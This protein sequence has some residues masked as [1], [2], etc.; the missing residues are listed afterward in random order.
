MLKIAR[1]MSDEGMMEKRL[2][3]NPEDVTVFSGHGFEKRSNIQGDV[4]ANEINVASLPEDM[5]AFIRKD[6]KPDINNFCYL[7]INALSDEETFGD[8]VNGDGMP[9]ETKHGDPCL[10]NE[11]STHGYKTYELFGHWY[12][13]HKNKHP[14]HAQGFVLYSSYDLDK[15]I[16]IILA[17][18]D[19]SKRP[20][21]CARVDKGI[22]P[23]TSMGIKVPFDLCSVCCEKH[24]T[25]DFVEDAIHEWYTDKSLQS[26]FADPGKFIVWHN[27]MH[28]KKHGTNIPGLARNTKE[29]CDHLKF[30]MGKMLPDGTK[31]YAI[32]HLPKCFDI[33]D[34]FSNADKVSQGL[35]KVAGR[36]GDSKLGG[37]FDFE[38]MH[39]P[40]ACT[41]MDDYGYDPQRRLFLLEGHSFING[42]A[43]AELAK[44]AEIEKE[45]ETKDRPKKLS[46]KDIQQLAKR[47][48]SDVIQAT[49]GLMNKMDEEHK[50]HPLPRDFMQKSTGRDI[51]E[52]VGAL[53]EA[54]II[55]TPEEF[56]ELVFRSVGNV[57]GAEEAKAK[58]H[59]FE[60]MDFGQT[61]LEMEKKVT[62]KIKD[63]FTK[64]ASSDE[65]IDSLAPV[66]AERT[67]FAPF[68]QKR[69]ERE[70]AK[71]GREGA[72]MMLDGQGGYKASG[73]MPIHKE[74]LQGYESL[75]HKQ[76]A[77]EFIKDYNE[78]DR[79][80]MLKTFALTS[81]LYPAVRNQIASSIGGTKIP[82]LSGN[83]AA[84]IA[85]SA[86]A[87]DQLLNWLSKDDPKIDTIE[88]TAEELFDKTAGLLEYA[89]WSANKAKAHLG[90]LATMPVI[91]GYALHQKRKAMRGERLNDLERWIA[92]NPDILS[93]GY[94]VAGP[95]LA[96][97]AKKKV[98]GGG[99]QKL[100][101]LELRSL[102][103]TRDRLGGNL[104]RPQVPK[105]IDSR[106]TGIKSQTTA[107]KKK[108]TYGWDDRLIGGVTWG[109][110]S[111]GSFL[112]A[113][114]AGLID[115]E[116]I[117]RLLD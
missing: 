90:A 42:D 26:Q 62:P 55:P 51:G 14:K 92:L 38:E 104:V 56:Q 97:A 31:V 102:Q 101:N 60:N 71:I 35:F 112:P 106:I 48:V 86:L 28:K 107:P 96:S 16:V 45:I 70:F 52:S 2:F 68:Y 113:F 46:E 78:R 9:R 32:N 29:Y 100:A 33:S 43:S 12:Q 10:K 111:P 84:L 22:M 1:L 19:R 81:V 67:F 6:F 27:E 89:P 5:Q 76:R 114:A 94:L 115:T 98:L 49:G 13:N 30:S 73:M 77:E 11:T 59:S 82:W 41:S 79:M 93:L 74:N 108:D 85:A 99:I 20:D 34:V 75:E 47:S 39:E 105:E 54:R 3:N 53:E 25:R 87:G 116:V 21:L 88:K 36:P 18:I 24:G 40:H 4:V 91:H 80:S 57:R 7:T 110:M 50:K 64:K 95:G 44:Q 72:V 23:L 103:V 17:G 61:G 58:G 8:N 66:F 63:L 15:G 65:L 69:A 109:L 37:F 117:H 83:Q